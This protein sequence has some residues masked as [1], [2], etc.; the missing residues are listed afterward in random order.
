[1]PRDTYTISVSYIK[2]EA[3]LFGATFWLKLAVP[4]IGMLLKA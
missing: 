2:L 4:V 3:T 1:M